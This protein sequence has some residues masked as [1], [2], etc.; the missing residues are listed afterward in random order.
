MPAVRRKIENEIGK[1]ANDMEKSVRDRTANIEYFMALPELGLHR[2][3]ILKTVET[4][5]NIGE[6]KWKDGRVSGAVYHFNED[7]IDL[8]GTVYQQTSYTNPLHSDIFPG[9]NKMEA[10]VVRMCAS[11]FNGDHESVGTVRLIGRNSICSLLTTFYI[12]I[13][14]RVFETVSD[15]N[16]VC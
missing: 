2:D 11:M 5:L 4:Y 12:Y 15:F 10:E 1:I 6:Y 8:V 3:D 7:L 9:I 14:S 13:L 16:S